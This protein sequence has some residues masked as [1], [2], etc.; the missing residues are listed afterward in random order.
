MKRVNKFLLTSSRE[1][2]SFNYTAL[3]SKTTRK[4]EKGKTYY[5]TNPAA[6]EGAV[7]ITSSGGSMS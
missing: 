4:K 3:G 7:S 2:K 1:K 5:S 6:A